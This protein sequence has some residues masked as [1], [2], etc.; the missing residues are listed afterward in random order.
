SIGLVMLQIVPCL[1]YPPGHA[2]ATLPAIVSLRPTN[3][4]WVAHINIKNNSKIFNCLRLEPQQ[5]QIG[6]KLYRGQCG[7][8]IFTSTSWPKILFNTDA[9]TN[10][11]VD[12]AKD[13][14]VFSI[15]GHSSA[16]ISSTID[17][18][19]A[20]FFICLDHQD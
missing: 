6:V 16:S 2:C 10:L 20:D 4:T 9:W 12:A 1:V 14:A 11:D 15:S 19:S 5:G 3:I 8:D 17:T 13:E 18:T 7:T